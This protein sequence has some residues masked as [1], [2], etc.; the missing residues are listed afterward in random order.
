MYKY[1][2]KIEMGGQST[3]LNFSTEIKEQNGGWTVTDRMTTPMGEAIDIS[4]LNKESLVLEKR[5]VKQGPVSI[6][7]D[8]K[9]NKATGS[10]TMNGQE[11]PVSVDTGGPLFADGAGGPQVV[12]CLPLAEGYS[13]TFRNFDVQKQKAKVMQLEVTGSEKVTVPAGSFDTYKTEITSGEGGPEKVTMWIAKDSRK[14]VKISAVLPQMGGAILTA[15]LE[16]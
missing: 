2:A 10:M 3:A 8:F 1:Q 11:R 7:L 9:D 14:A 15:E 13:T 5:S 12:G 16:E 4:Q 6:D